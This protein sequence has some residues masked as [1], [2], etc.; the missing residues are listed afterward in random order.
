[1][2]TRH[3]LVKRNISFDS[4]I[5]L[6]IQN[7]QIVSEKCNHTLDDNKTLE[8]FYFDISLLSQLLL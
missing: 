2:E 3:L 7:I 6:L 5:Q 4:E 8:I 1:M